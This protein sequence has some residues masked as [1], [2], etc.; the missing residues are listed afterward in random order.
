[1]LAIILPLAGFL[2]ALFVGRWRRRGGRSP[3]VVVGGVLLIGPQAQLLQRVG[4]SPAEA[5]L[6]ALATMVL[7]PLVGYLLGFRL[8]DRRELSSAAGSSRP[9]D[10]E[11]PPP[12]W[13][14]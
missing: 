8:W 9:A 5:W 3:V 14:I 1:M 7:V 10:A 13:E 6:V 11:E 12:T 2:V 4:L